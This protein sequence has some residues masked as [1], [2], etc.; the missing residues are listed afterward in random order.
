MPTCSTCSSLRAVALASLSAFASCVTTNLETGKVMP[1]DGQKYT[2]D[3]VEKKAEQLHNGM[4]KLDV[5]LLL[6]SPAE[7]DESS[8]LWVY[9]PERYGVLI[10]ARALRLEFQNNKLVEFGYRPI[11]L[12]TRL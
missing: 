6:G 5:H 3:E 4:S 7:K 9:L 12:G 1:R 11:V 2:F 8:G 10:P